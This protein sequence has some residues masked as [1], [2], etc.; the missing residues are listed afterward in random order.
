MELPEFRDKGTFWVTI[1]A[2]VWT[3]FGHRNW[4]YRE[5]RK[6]ANAHENRQVFLET[7]IIRMCFF[8]NPVYFV[9]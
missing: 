2:K 9:S 6:R 3:S 5:H 1:W 4:V 7:D 8:M